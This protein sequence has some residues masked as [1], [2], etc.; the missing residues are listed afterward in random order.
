MTFLDYRTNLISPT[1]FAVQISMLIETPYECPHCGEPNLIFVDT[2]EGD[3]ETIEDC[4]VCCRPIRLRITC[5]EGE[6][7]FAEPEIT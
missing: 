1:L 6:S 7:P 5:P 3:Y 2:S 4:T